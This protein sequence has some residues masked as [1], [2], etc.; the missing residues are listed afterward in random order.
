MRMCFFGS[1]IP[2]NYC[3]TNENCMNIIILKNEC[4]IERAYKMVRPNMKDGHGTR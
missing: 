4:V 3:K 1:G 2:F